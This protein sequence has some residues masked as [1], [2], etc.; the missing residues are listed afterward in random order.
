MARRVHSDAC[1]FKLGSV[2]FDFQLRVLFRGELLRLNTHPQFVCIDG[3]LD[4]TPYL[5][6]PRSVFL[7]QNRVSP[8]KCLQEVARFPCA[9]TATRLRK[10]NLR[11]IHIQRSVHPPHLESTYWDPF[12]EGIDRRQ[13]GSRSNSSTQTLSHF[14]LV[15]QYEVIQ[16]GCTGGSTVQY[17]ASTRREMSGR[18]Y[19][20]W[21]RG[22]GKRERTGWKGKGLALMHA[23]A[24]C[25]G[26]NTTRRREREKGGG[27]ASIE[28]WA[29]SRRECITTA[30]LAFSTLQVPRHASLHTLHAHFQFDREQSTLPTSAACSLHSTRSQRIFPPQ[31][32]TNTKQFPS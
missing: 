21:H 8:R 26:A 22:E 32:R 19:C 3:E 13:V 5:R 20:K 14:G 24:R 29:V 1:M 17:S 10:C 6:I 18:Q 12:A 9:C 15:A 25:E 2:Q 23:P 7:F 16:V 4:A 11:S 31:S 30:S 27:G 28:L